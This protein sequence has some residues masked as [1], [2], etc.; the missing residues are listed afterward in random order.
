MGIDN[1]GM[2]FLFAAGAAGVSFRKTATLG[3]Q[4]FFPDAA[5]LQKLLDARKPGLS[6]GAFQEES[7][8][9]AEKFFEFLGAEEVVAID[10]SSY[11]GASVVTDMNAP[12]DPS[13]K[14][15]FSA[16]FDGGC[17]EHVFNFPQAIR[18]CMEMLTVGGHFIAVTPA[19][20]FCG[21]GF[22]Q[23]SPELF[24]RIFS[25]DN[26]F[27]IRAIL[28]KEKASWYRVVDPAETGGRVELQ[29]TRPTYLFVLAQKTTM[30]D[31]F[32]H[33]PQQSDYRKRW[34]ENAGGSAGSGSSGA[35]RPL[36]DF[37]PLQ[38]KE[39]LRPFYVNLPIR[40]RS[41]YYV[42]IKEARLLSGDF[43]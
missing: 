21:H 13:L 8:G 7:H 14:N 38:L 35:G 17:L 31:P 29:N 32:T 22:Y 25:A 9:Y 23:F 26:G 10:N 28:T 36:R 4:N 11:E 3:R 19:N 41:K 5:E 2:K 12:V 27:A 1:N 15:R 6:A 43:G 16:I 40:F 34:E 42:A 30:K 18:N 33:A 20:N 37:V 39:R 24:F